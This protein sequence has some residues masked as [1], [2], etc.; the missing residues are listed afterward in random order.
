MIFLVCVILANAMFYKGLKNLHLDF[1]FIQAMAY[2]IVFGIIG[3]LV[4][5]PLAKRIP[6]VPKKDIHKQ[7]E[8]T[9]NIFKYLQITTAFYI[10]FAHGSNDVAN[11][12]GPLAAVVSILKSGTVE[13]K[14]AMPSLDSRFRGWVYCT[15]TSSLGQ[16]RY[17]DHREIR[18][19]RLLRRVVFVLLL[20]VLQ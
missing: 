16:A 17:G 3:F 10:A 7:L 2:S 20:P 9:E 4:S 1:S 19:P 12:V 6:D 11:A 5:R 18:S 15:R 8:A 14:V 13:M